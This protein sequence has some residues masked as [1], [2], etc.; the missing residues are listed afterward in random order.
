LF[1]IFLGSSASAQILVEAF[2]SMTCGNCAGPDSSY[3]KFLGQHPQYKAEVVYIHN[4]IPVDLDLFYHQSKA[5]VDSRSSTLYGIIS[6]PNMFINGFSEGSSFS[7]WT[8]QTTAAASYVYHGTITASANVDGAGQLQVDLHINGSGGKQVRPCVMLVESGIKHNNTYEY[9]N[10]PDT[11]WNNIFRAMIPT[12]QGG[13][14]FSLNGTT[15]LHFTYDPTGKP[16]VL[17]NCKLVVFLQDVAASTGVNHPIE[18]LTTASITTAGVSGSNNISV[19]SIGTPIPNPSTTSAQIPFHLAAPANVKI[20][21]CD[22]LGREVETIFNRFAEGSS[23][24]T[25]MPNNLSRGIYYA[26]MFA[27]GTF[28]G[29]QKI[30]FA[31]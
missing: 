19:S 21:V 11:I 9:G 28:V 15:D 18:A 23:F 17:S 13:D 6:N 25:F 12:T 27:D 5:D 7:T 30:V 1:S 16:W 22:D 26:R 14:P 24:A 8:G 10:L 2:R 20:V 29:M 4:A 31:P 3:E